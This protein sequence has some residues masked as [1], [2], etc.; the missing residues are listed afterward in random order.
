MFTGLLFYLHVK[1]HQVRRLVFDNYQWCPVSFRVNTF[2]QTFK[3]PGQTRREK[4]MHGSHEN[5][6]SM[7]A[8][9]RNGWHNATNLCVYTPKPNSTLLSRPPFLKK[10]FKTKITFLIF[11]WTK[12]KNSFQ[13]KSK[14]FLR[15]KTSRDCGTFVWVLRVSGLFMRAQLA[16]PSGPTSRTLSWLKPKFQNLN[17]FK[18]EQCYATLWRFDSLNK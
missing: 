14:I 9:L 13:L 16:V 18:N 3:Q 17:K 5:Q 11:K 15:R 1:I 12:L 2:T 8:F 4:N 10:V 6:P 7:Q